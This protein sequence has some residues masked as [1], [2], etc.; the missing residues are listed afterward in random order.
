MGG[1][2]S[3]L[4][5]GTLGSPQAKIP[6]AQIEDTIGS[7]SSS[8][9]ASTREALLSEATS[10]E[11]QRLIKELYRKGATVGDGGT[12]DAI[13]EELATGNPTG[14]RSHIQ[15]GKERL[16]QIERMLEKYPEH[17]DR[18]LLERLRDDLQDALE[19]N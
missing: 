7:T 14:G 10:D 17:A 15:K 13:R 16:R 19:G 11:V 12:A 2:S 3:D 6:V 8:A 1:F 9:V 5:H 18:A 4:F